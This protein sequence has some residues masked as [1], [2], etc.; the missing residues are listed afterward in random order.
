MRLPV[1]CFILLAWTSFTCF[2][3]FARKKSMNLFEPVGAGGM[4]LAICCNSRRLWWYKCSWSYC[5][6]DYPEGSPLLLLLDFDFLSDLSASLVLAAF[7][8]S[9]FEDVHDNSWTGE[10][11]PPLFEWLELDLLIDDY[12]LSR[13]EAGANFEILFELIFWP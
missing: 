10:S 5:L 8:A 12:G 1:S 11:C 9:S 7:L 6:D 2:L 13:G 4:L 3:V